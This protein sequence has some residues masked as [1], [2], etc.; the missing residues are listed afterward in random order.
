MF[1]WHY[2]QSQ[3]G[4]SVRWQ[5]ICLF[6]ENSKQRTPSKNG[7][8]WDQFGIQQQQHSARDS[9]ENLCNKLQ[10]PQC[11]GTACQTRWSGSS[12]QLFLAEMTDNLPLTTL[13]GSF[14]QLLQLVYSSNRIKTSCLSAIFFHSTLVKYVT[15][16]LR[17]VTDIWGTVGFLF[18]SNYDRHS[19]GLGN[20]HTVLL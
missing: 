11:S 2:L 20:I 17:G 10:Y 16:C 13:R 1:T 9:T 4:T 6:Q 15:T 18:L 7:V 8:I 12:F 5:T 19:T 14:A 3:L